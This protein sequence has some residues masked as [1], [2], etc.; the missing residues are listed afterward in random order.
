MLTE[1]K[2]TEFLKEITDLISQG[3]EENGKL[4]SEAGRGQQVIHLFEC[5]M[6]T[7]IMLGVA[8]FLFSQ[9]CYTASC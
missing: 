9:N 2:Q 6:M 4:T 8:G 3:T 5:L 1:C 7:K